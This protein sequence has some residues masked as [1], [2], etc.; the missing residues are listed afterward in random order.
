MV[1][2][3]YASSYFSGKSESYA[4][5]FRN[6]SG[7]RSPFNCFPLLLSLLV[8]LSLSRSSS[9]PYFPSP[10]SLLFSSSSSLVH[11]WTTVYGLLMIHEF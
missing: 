5:I 10:L 7:A 3:Y 6:D 9:L 4:P 2:L 8:L 11:N 1:S